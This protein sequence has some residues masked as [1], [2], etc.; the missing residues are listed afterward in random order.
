[1]HCKTKYTVKQVQK[2][3]YVTE[4]KIENIAFKKH[5]FGNKTLKPLR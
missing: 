3:K 1:M 5:C 4:C 2:V